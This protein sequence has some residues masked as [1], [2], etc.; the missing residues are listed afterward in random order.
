MNHQALARR[1]AQ[2][3]RKP[4][5]RIHT[6]RATTTVHLVIPLGNGQFHT[7]S[8]KV[9]NREIE[10]LL[11]RGGIELTVGFSL[12]G[13]WNSVKKAAKSVGITKVL[14][15][16]AKVLNNPVLN[17][18]LPVTAVTGRALNVANGLLAVHKGAGKGN[19]KAKAALVQLQAKARAGKVSPE[20][21]KGMQL[22]ERI[23]TIR[24]TP[25]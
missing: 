24:V 3:A 23:Y 9:D 10:K 7:C 4:W 5:L 2:S 6:T 18:V 19:P 14:S 12:G 11:R 22:A 17:A 15:L 20:V 21:K 8:V 13:L 25:A 1:V 16:G